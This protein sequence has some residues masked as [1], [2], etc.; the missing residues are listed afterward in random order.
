M[1]DIK[2]LYEGRTSE[3]YI[4]FF[5]PLQ[6]L[7]ESDVIQTLKNIFF[8]HLLSKIEKNLFIFFS[9]FTFIASRKK[10]P[11]FIKMTKT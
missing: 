8:F 3:F 4:K 11:S 5:P 7:S 2:K 10:D 1:D 6:N 9:T